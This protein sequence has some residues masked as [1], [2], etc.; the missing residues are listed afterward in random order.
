M[1]TK[2]VV[3]GVLSVVLTVQPLLAAD[4]YKLLSLDGA[5]VKWPARNGATIVTYAI[6]TDAT[7]VP[8]I[9]NC[10]KTTG[11][12]TLLSRSSLAEDA[13]HLA[14]AKAFRLWSTAAD[15]QF[16]QAAPHKQADLTITAESEPDG[17]AFTDLTHASVNITRG[18][19]CLNPEVSWTANDV[20]PEGTYRLA[21]VLAHEIGHAIG[22]DHPSP[23]GELMS[24]EYSPVRLGLETGDI[25][26]AV[27]LYGPA[28]RLTADASHH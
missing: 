4:G 17:I 5:N 14:L 10:R 8:G 28:R 2:W 3:A 25:A 22:L 7:A 11:L 16:V 9:D 12:K 19:I 26:G 20:G 13:F 24:F 15:V 1:H 21:Y 27:I 18:V 23:D 6:A